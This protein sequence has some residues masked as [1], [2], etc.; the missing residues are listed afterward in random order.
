[1]PAAIMGRNLLLVFWFCDESANGHCVACV[2]IG[3]H[4]AR[5]FCS[6]MTGV[7]T[8]LSALEPR[9]LAITQKLMTC[10]ANLTTLTKT[11]AKCKCMKAN[12]HGARLT[13]ELPDSD[14][15]S[16]LQEKVLI[17]I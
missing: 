13:D 5:W 9:P 15:D 4:P 11:G 8:S 1:M 3:V 7:S 17:D 12:A 6:E 2:A 14:N 16:S 10:T